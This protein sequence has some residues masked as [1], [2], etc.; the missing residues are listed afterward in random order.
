MNDA[1][2]ISIERARDRG[3]D[4]PSP[5]QVESAVAAIGAISHAAEKLAEQQPEMERTLARLVAFLRRRLTGDYS[6]DDFG[7]DQDL[8]ENILL[9]L[10]R[11]L[12]NSWFRVDA[13]GV[14]NIPADG[15]ALLVANHAG[16]IPLDGLML[17]LAVHDEHPAQ[18]FVRL[19]GAD[20]V[21]STPVVGQLARKTGATLACTPDAERLLGQGELVGVFP[22]GFKGVGKG[23]KQRYRLQRFGRGGFVMSAIRAQVPI[24]PTSIVGSEETYP[25]IANIKPLAR[26]LGLP[27]LPITPLFPLLGLLGIVPL[28]SKWTIDFGTPVETTHLG[29]AAADDPMVV[30]ELADQIRETI[31]QTLYTLLGER[32]GVFI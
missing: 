9:P 23:W 15:P 18:R 8:T 16:T 4:G 20:L 10:A 5:R 32:P 26:A 21:F 12:Y 17:N 13:R 24:I 27:Y 22:E 14:G 25:M 1:E 28:P 31:Q 19:L 2:V 30:F 6:V 3:E 11:P 29:V 7:F